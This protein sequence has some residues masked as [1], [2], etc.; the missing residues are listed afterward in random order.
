MTRLMDEH[1][2]LQ[3]A[4]DLLSLKAE[5]LALWVSRYDSPPVQAAKEA[6]RRILFV[7]LRELERA[8]NEGRDDHD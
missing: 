8:I 1:A 3:A 7:R 6:A 5:E 2:N 4:H